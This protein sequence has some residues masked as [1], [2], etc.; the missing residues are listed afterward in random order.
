MN[1]HKED[2][3]EAFQPFYQ[4]TYLQEE[5][6]NVDLIYRK[7]RK[8]CRG[9]AFVYTDEDIEAFVKEYS[10]A[11]VDRIKKLMESYDK[12]V[13]TCCQTGYNKKTPDKSV[14]S[15]DGNFVASSNGSIAIFRLLQIFDK[16]L[17]KEFYSV[18]KHINLL[19][20]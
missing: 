1:E 19:P 7:H 17:H 8:N 3:L 4:E 6:Q 11:E 16:E 9:Y 15:L 5:V 14:I 2:I 20:V 13:N 12:P 10:R 18:L